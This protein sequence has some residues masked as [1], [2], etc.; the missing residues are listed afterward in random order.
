MRYCSRMA[1][2]N[3][4]VGILYSSPNSSIS[5]CNDKLDK[6]LSVIQEAKKNV[7][8]NTLNVF[9]GLSLDNQTFINLFS[10]HYY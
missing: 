9:T 8:V 1:K 4:I 5:V 2:C 10:A 3:I 7:Y 6:M